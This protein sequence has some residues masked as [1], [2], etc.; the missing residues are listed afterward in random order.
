MDA[1][2]AK[3]TKDIK[4]KA[5]AGLDLGRGKGLAFDEKKGRLYASGT[6]VK[7][8]GK[9][10]H[11][12]YFDLNDGG[13][14]HGVLAGERTGAS[15]VY[16]GP[17]DG[18]KGYAEHSIAF[19]PDDPEKR[20]LYMRLTD[21]KTFYRLDLEKRMVAACSGPPRGKAGP[22]MF[23]ESGIP[24]GMVPHMAPIWLPGGD[25]LMPGLRSSPAPYFRRVK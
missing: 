3:Q 2:T 15:A 13:S 21:T 4:L 12:W 8:D 20:F 14:F 1:A 11:V 17:F 6:I 19:G 10:W 9:Q 25:F 24:N 5:T 22:V 23:I 16:A 18:F 7:K